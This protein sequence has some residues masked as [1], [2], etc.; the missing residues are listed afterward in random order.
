MPNSISE[1]ASQTCLQHTAPTTSAASSGPKNC[2][3]L[4]QRAAHSVRLRQMEDR[5]IRRI[6]AK[7]KELGFGIFTDGEFRREASCRDFR[8]RRRRLYDRRRARPR[9]EEPAGRRDASAAR[10][11]HREAPPEAPPH[12]IRADVSQSEQP[13]PDQDD[14]AQRH[15]IS[16]DLPSRPASPTRRTQIIRRCSGTSSRS[17][18]ASWRGFRRRAESLHSNRRAALQLFHRPKWRE[19]MRTE[20]K[21]RAGRAARRIDSRRQRS[22]SRRRRD[23]A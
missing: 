5:H 11:R 7:Q 20:M 8:R 18:K 22:A 6:L 3:M 9:L 15:A 23:P 1:G 17:W 19:F 16:C 12:R 14:A 10:R 4:A 2:S 13:G 21:A